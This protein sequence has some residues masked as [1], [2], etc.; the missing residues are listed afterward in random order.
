MLAGSGAKVVML[1]T[2]C[3]L[4]QSRGAAVRGD[5]PVALLGWGA[6]DSQDLGSCTGSEGRLFRVV[7]TS[8]G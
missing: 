8:W 4:D 2:G 7:L 6:W 5:L 3:V 1:M